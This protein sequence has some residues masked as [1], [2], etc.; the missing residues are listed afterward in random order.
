MA[1]FSLVVAAALITSGVSGLG[2]FKIPMGLLALVR[3][4]QVIFIGGK[5][6]NTARYEELD[7][8]LDETR[9]H[10]AKYPEF[11]A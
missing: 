11:V 4:S 8:K 7:A 3:L 9:R 6:A 2:T 10:E 1:L 5:P